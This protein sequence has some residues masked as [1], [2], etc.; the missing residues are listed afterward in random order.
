M[1]LIRTIRFILNHP[2][3]KHRKWKAFK[4]YLKWQLSGFLNNYSVVFPFIEN[5]RL[6]I[7]KGMTGATGNIYT[8]LLEFDDML[9]LLHYLNSD[10]FFLDIG[11]NVGIYSVLAAGVKEAKVIA[12]EPIPSTFKH[13]YDNILINNLFKNVEVKNIGLGKKEGVLKFTQE[14]D[15]ANHVIS[16]NE[17]T[18]NS[19][20]VNIKRLDEIIDSSLPTML[21]IDVEGFESEV[22]EGAGVILSSESLMAIIVELNGLGSRY[23]FSDENV[24]NLLIK[25]GFRPVK[26][27]PFKRIITEIEKYE[28]NHNTIYLKNINDAQKRVS[29]SRKFKILDNNY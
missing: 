1:E 7:K 3:N 18:R 12:F 14:F 29:Q 5:T 8:G 13:L 25:K 22:L 9:F 17:Y 11:A 28:T 26:Y 27:D 21:K 4:T 24:H 16:T 23:G 2:A 6:I 10:D 15:A 20:E 19:I